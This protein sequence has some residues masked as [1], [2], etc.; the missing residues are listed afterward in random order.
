M[1]GFI[2]SSNFIFQSILKLDF[3]ILLL[4]YI[5]FCL[6]LSIIKNIRSLTDVS[7]IS[8]YLF[9]NEGVL[10]T[11]E[12]N[13]PFTIPTIVTKAKNPSEI[14]PKELL[15]RTQQ[16]YNVGNNPINILANIPRQLGMHVGATPIQ[17]GG[18]GNFFF[19][20]MSFNLFF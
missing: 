20:E 1:I 13:I 18:I 16:Q 4:P 9:S 7:R 19:D 17:S 8:K 12:K 11:L 2:Y 6:S 3:I 10:N 5:L 14:G 15:Y